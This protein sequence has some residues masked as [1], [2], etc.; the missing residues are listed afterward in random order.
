MVFSITLFLFCT[1]QY[2]GY[3]MKSIPYS[4]STRYFSQ[5]L[6]TYFRLFAFARHFR[7]IF[8]NNIIA[9]W[10]KNLFQVT[11]SS[12]FFFFSIFIKI[13][14][15]AGDSSK[16]LTMWALIDHPFGLVSVAKCEKSHLDWQ[17]VSAEFTTW[18]RKQYG[19]VRE[20]QEKTLF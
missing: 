9:N 11:S 17:Y 14:R 18:E 10:H 5:E 15:N 6:S 1:T 3:F 20:L 19:K 7:S 4:V 13:W 2:V 8:S 12:I 16:I